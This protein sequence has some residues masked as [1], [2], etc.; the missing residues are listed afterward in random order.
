[1]TQ[2]RTSTPRSLADALRQR[3]DHELQTLLASRPDLLHPVPSDFTALAARATTGPSVS[4]CLDA[5]T[6]L[7]LYTL[8]VA[9]RLSA[10]T[11]VAPGAIAE[12]VSKALGP[13]ALE[14]AQASVRRLTDLALLWGPADQVRAIHPVREAMTSVQ[15]PAWPEPQ[16]TWTRMMPQAD[17]DEQSGGHAHAAI[18][19]IRELLEAWSVEPPGVLRTGGLAIRDFAGA[20]RLLNSDAPT[21]SLT[22]EVSQAAGLLADDGAGRPTW[23]PTDAYDL[24]LDAVPPKQW[25][26]LA[27]AWLSMPRL[28]AL[29]TE[30]S[31][32]LSSELDRRAVIGLRLAILALLAEAPPGAIVDPAS[33]AAV[34]DYRQPRRSGPL[35]EQAIAATFAEGLCLGVLVGGALSTPGRLLI[36]AP[37]EAREARVQA[38]MADAMPAEIDHVLI[39]ADLTMVAPGPVAP[40]LGAI[41]GRVAD[42]ESRGHA[43]VYRISESSIQRALDSGWDAAQI[44]GALA[45]ASTTGVPQPLAYLIDDTARRHGAVRVGL[46]SSYLRCDNEATL[47]AIL[48]DRRLKTLDLSRIADTVIVSQASSPELIAGL[49]TAGYA[50]AAESP[51]GTIVVRSPQEHRAP[52]PRHRR[53]AASRKDPAALIAAAVKGLRSGD[54]AATAPRGATIAGPAGVSQVRSTTSTATVAALRSAIADATP[55]WIGYADTD[56]TTTE[57]IID[58]IRLGGG[59]VTAFDHRTEQVRSFMVAR[60]SGV[61]PLEDET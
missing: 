35:R 28:P 43:T 15:P 47:S 17:I 56:G 46:A 24:W 10:E 23:T 12:A 42:V 8:S 60:I 44:R 22:I 48:G 36:S 32:V 29:A 11:A 39:Q 50:P 37:A 16:L 2:P 14:A 21:S 20:V 58:P 30:R 25:A 57:Q 52:S 4:R 40:A 18:A 13:D 5:L 27:V 49:R 9:A 53:V 38:A 1:M 34:L 59:M 41:L 54:R 45:D 55:V 6:A 33:V 19:Q 31:N 3:E 51:D 61:A 26:A 7:D